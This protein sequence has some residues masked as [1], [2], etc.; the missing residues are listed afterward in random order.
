MAFRAV[1]YLALFAVALADLPPN[2]ESLTAIQKQEILWNNIN[3]DVYD[4]DNL[5][6][7]GPTPAQLVAFMNVNFTLQT[8]LLV[9]DE[10]P[11]GRTK[12][13]HPYGP[14][15]KARMVIFPN[16]RYTGIFSPG[17]THC[18]VRPSPGSFNPQNLVPGLGVKCL[19]D[20]APSQNIMSLFAFAG[21]GTNGNYFEN[22][23]FNI[24]LTDDRRTGRKIT[25]PHLEALATKAGEV[26]SNTRN[27]V[28]D[29]FEATLAALP[30]GI[31]DRPEDT[32]NM[33]LYEQASVRGDGS[34]VPAGQVV[35]P[36]KI[37]F[38]P[39]R[40]LSYPADTD[41][42]FRYQFGQIEP[43]TVVYQVVLYRTALSA[44]GELVGHL[45]S[46][47]PFV[48]SHYADNRFFMRHGRQ[49]WQSE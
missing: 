36:Y 11:V 39:N 46:D 10:M 14:V 45:V 22:S 4:Y 1:L 7:A 6:T 16:S 35:A 5:P 12:V 28:N 43:G 19:I 27:P 29:L 8:F 26:G 49:R 38:V 24:P 41:K 20:G 9:S 3:A 40:L 23:K 15:A 21:Q 13:I 42:D 34:L 48:S 44:E 32:G 31:N 2:Y 17:Q 25:C 33:P 37:E 47:S 30:G 18:L